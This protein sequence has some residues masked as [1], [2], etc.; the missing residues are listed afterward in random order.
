MRTALGSHTNANDSYIDCKNNRQ[1]TNTS[2]NTQIRTQS[3]SGSHTQEQKRGHQG[4]LIKI[5]DLETQTRGLRT[6]QREGLFVSQEEVVSE[7]DVR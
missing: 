5:K 1:K 4:P 6:M 7:R 3:A 2:I